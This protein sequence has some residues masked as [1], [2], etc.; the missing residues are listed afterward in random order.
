MKGNSDKSRLVLKFLLFSLPVI[1]AVIGGLILA[2]KLSFYPEV[3]N[4]QAGTYEEANPGSGDSVDTLPGK[5]VFNEII[6]STDF[7]TKAV[8]N[9]MVSVLNCMERKLDFVRISPQISYTMTENLYSKL[10][11]DNPKLPQT[12]LLSELYDYYESDRA[13]SAGARIVSEMLGCTID[14]YTAADKE[15][16]DKHIFFREEESG[17]NASCMIT[18]DDA[19]NAF[20]GTEGSAEGYIGYAVKNT[21]TDF[22]LENRM[23]YLDIYNDLGQEDITFWDAPVK[24]NNETYEL[25]VNGTSAI[26]IKLIP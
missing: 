6:F 24:K 3:S 5:A 7:E 10:I 21:L 26:M 19:K 8:T 13:Y 25:D 20:W 22:S 23:V 11:P 9:I 17:I 12:V 2:K 15:I 1:L 4:G 14:C 16:F 18:G